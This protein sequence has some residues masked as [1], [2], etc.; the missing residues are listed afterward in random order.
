MKKIGILGT[1]DVGQALARG[2]ILDNYEVMVGSRDGAKAAHL[3]V[4]LDQ[5]INAGTFRDVAAWAEV[6]VLAVK[7]SASEGVA[8]DL[9]DVLAGKV[10][11]DVTNPIADGE[12]EDGVLKYFTTLEESL[13]ERVQAA[14]PDA[15]V[16]KAWNSVGHQFMMH[17]EFPDTPTMPICGNDAEARALVADIVRSFGWEVEDMGTMKA[18][19]AIE[20]LCML[21]CIPGFLRNDWSHA[22]KILK[23]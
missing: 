1:G 17:P 14:A 3:D 18:A 22:F 8:G 20:P 13:G 4:V 15:K 6:V 12:P 5:N 10:V 16:V 9:A 21:W 2:F 11:I 7:G 19:R 23:R